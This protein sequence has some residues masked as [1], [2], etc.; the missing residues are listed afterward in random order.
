MQTVKRVGMVL[1]MGAFGPVGFASTACLVVAA[2]AL[3]GCNQDSYASTPERDTHM[4]DIRA[5]PEPSGTIHGLS[6]TGAA[7]APMAASPVAP[8]PNG[9][10]AAVPPPALPASPRGAGAPAAAGA[11]PRPATAG[12]VKTPPPAP[13]SKT[14]P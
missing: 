7:P 13:S 8:G 5:A 4:G 9:S 10:V 3:V 1:A 12:S 11:V 6:A 2:G 14:A